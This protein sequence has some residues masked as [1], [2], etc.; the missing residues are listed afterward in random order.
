LAADVLGEAD[1]A[2]AIYQDLKF[3]VIG[4]LPHDQ[5]TLAE[6]QLRQAIQQ[7]SVSQGR[8]P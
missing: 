4:R 1:Q 8:T 2:Q 3:K 7:I 5:W 6:D